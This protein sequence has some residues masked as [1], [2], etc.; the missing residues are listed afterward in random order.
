MFYSGT[1]N[2]L[3][4]ALIIPTLKHCMLNNIII[5]LCRNSYTE[6]GGFGGLT[7]DGRIAVASLATAF[8]VGSVLF[9]VTGFLC[10]H[11]CRKGKKSMAPASQCEKTITHGT[12]Y[13]DDVVLNQQQELELKGN[14]AYA[15][16]Q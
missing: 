12:P 5:M 16:V 2:Q 14:V 15:P 10:G 13:Y 6:S 3:S 8:V 9:F 4:N 1:A 7:G 11:Y